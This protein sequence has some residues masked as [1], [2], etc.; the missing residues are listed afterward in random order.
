MKTMHWRM[1][2]YPVAELWHLSE[3]TLCHRIRDVN[4][5]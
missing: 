3:I 1:Q 4:H 2:T 5:R